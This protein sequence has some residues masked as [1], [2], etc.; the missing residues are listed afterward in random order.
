MLASLECDE[1][2]VTKN[3]HMNLE[4]M[5]R[6]PI[7]QGGVHLQRQIP[8]SYVSI[9]LCVV[10]VVFFGDPAFAQPKRDFSY[11]PAQARSR[12]TLINEV[13]MTPPT[14]KWKKWEVSIEQAWLEK[15]R[16]GGCY[17]CFRIANGKEALDIADRDAGFFVMGDQ[18]GSAR[19]VH[20]R[21]WIQVVEHLESDDI[22][23]VRFSFIG[24]SM[25]ERPKNIRFVVKK[26]DG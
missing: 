3:S 19:H 11:S 25:D 16:A 4:G 9:F 14:F 5:E 17:L 2:C 7:C 23:K 12:G 26:K 6:S 8:K 24:S 20:A 1:I 15:C 21:N 22:A 18:K 13:E 10:L